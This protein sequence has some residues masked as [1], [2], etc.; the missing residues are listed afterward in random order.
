[1]VWARSTIVQVRLCSVLWERRCSHGAWLAGA[2]STTA[3]GQSGGNALSLAVPGK[4]CQ[5]P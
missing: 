1:M 3:S 5:F 4:F 2:Q